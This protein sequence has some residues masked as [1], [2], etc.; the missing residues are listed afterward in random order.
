MAP[1]G[2]ATP[3]GTMAAGHVA[4]ATPNL[5]LLEFT[6]Y[7]AKAYTSLT[8]LSKLADKRADAEGMC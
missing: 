4:A 7:V 3:L 5:M 8:E 2:V 1:H 6:H